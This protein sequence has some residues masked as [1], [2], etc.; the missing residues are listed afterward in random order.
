MGGEGR[1]TTGN[2][3]PR[4]DVEGNPSSALNI[5]RRLGVDADPD[6]DDRRAATVRKAGAAFAQEA[7]M[8]IPKFTNTEVGSD[9]KTGEWAVIEGILH[10]P[11]E[12]LPR[13]SGLDHEDDSSIT[14]ERDTPN[15][16]V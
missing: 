5:L 7:S 15:Q 6:I 1:D 12:E 13:E 10:V 11:E 14:D 4:L 8:V 2:Y 3:E 9:D 16:L